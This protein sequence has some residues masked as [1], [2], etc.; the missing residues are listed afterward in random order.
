MD[1]RKSSGCM[2]AALF[3]VNGGLLGLVPSFLLCY[4]IATGGAMS[5]GVFCGCVAIGGVICALLA[6]AF[7]A[8]IGPALE[9][10]QG[11]AEAKPPKEEARETTAVECPK[12][13]LINPQ[14]AVRCDC[15]YDFTSGRATAAGYGKQHPTLAQRLGISCAWGLGCGLLGTLGG[16]GLWACLLRQAEEKHPVAIGALGIFLYVG[17]H[18]GLLPPSGAVVG[19]LIGFIVSFWLVTCGRGRPTERGGS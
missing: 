5:D 14:T 19:G 1:T 6:G 18:G 16:C 15:G 3:A 10:R 12:C 7:G 17:G 2:W 8:L 11:D 9:G 4:A 13:G